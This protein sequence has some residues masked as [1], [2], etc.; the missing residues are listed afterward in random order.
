MKKKIQNLLKNKDIQQI[1]KYIV[2]GVLTTLVNWAVYFSLTFLLKPENY[3][4]GSFEHAAILNISNLAGWILSVIFAFFTN[5]KYVFNSTSN[6]KKSKWMEFALFVSARVLSL[7][8][9]DVALYNV[10]IYA[11]NMQHG[12]VKIL[13]NVLVVVFN[14]FAS[15]FVIFRQKK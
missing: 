13:M 14:Y 3:L 4:K 10:C 15:R 12:V 5:R 9:F 1:I 11:F 6:D 8:L 7:L 2:F